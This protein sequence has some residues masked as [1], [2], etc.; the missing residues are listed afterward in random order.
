MKV[1]GWY[2]EDSLTCLSC[3]SQEEGEPAYAVGLPDGFT[4]DECG[5]V[6]LS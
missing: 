2:L 5:K 6:V 3:T 4:C 1:I